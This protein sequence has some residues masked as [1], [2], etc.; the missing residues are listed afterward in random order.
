[1]P[2]AHT[3]AAAASPIAAA[4]APHR[5]APSSSRID[6]KQIP[7]AQVEMVGDE[8]LYYTDCDKAPPASNSTF[9]ALDQGNCNP[10]FVRLT[11]YRVAATEALVDST[12]LVVG[13]IIQPLAR[14]GTDEQQVPVI[15]IDAQNP[16]GPVRCS[17]C[18]AY[19]NHWNKF[20]DQ[21]RRWTCIMC[22]H[23]NKVADYYY[24]NLDANG[25][26]R[27]AGVRA[28]LAYGTVEYAA[29]A[30]YNVRKT[31]ESNILYMI[32]ASQT[33]IQSGLFAAAADGVR[34][35]LKHHAK[36]PRAMIGLCTYG[37]SVNF[38]TTNLNQQ[39][40]QMLEVGDIDDPFVPLPYDH[41][42]ARPHDP[43]G[44]ARLHSILDTMRNVHVNADNSAVA[45]FG[46]AIQV[47]FEALKGTGGRI[48]IVQASMPQHGIGKL[49]PRDD[50]NLY[51]TDKERMLFRPQTD[52]YRNIAVQCAEAGVA[53]DMFVGASGYLDI[54]TT[55][56]LSTSTGGQVYYYDNFSAARSVTLCQDISRNAERESGCDGVMVVRAS[57]GLRPSEYYGNFFRRRPHEIEL[58]GIDADKAFAV[59]FAHDSKLNVDRRACFQCAL[60]YTTADGHRRIR[61]HT[62]A[63]PVTTAMADI[64]RHSDVD[65]IVAL[66]LKQAGRQILHPSAPKKVRAALTEACIDCLAVYRKHCASSTSRGQLILPEPL[67]LLPFYTFGMVKHPLFHGGMYADQRSH[68][69]ACVASMPIA[70][71][72]VFV[73]PALFDVLHMP[74]AACVEEDGQIFLPPTIRLSREELKSDSIYVLDNGFAIYMWVGPQVQPEVQQQLFDFSAAHPGA[75][76]TVSMQWLGDPDHVSSRVHCMFKKI[77]GDRPYFQELDIIDAQQLQQHQM[78]QHQQP[79]AGVGSGLDEKEF[80]KHLIE[81]EGG[82]FNYTKLLQASLSKSGSGASSNKSNSLPSLMSMEQFLCHLHQQIVQRI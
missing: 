33:S 54:A 78:Q 51:N 43:E 5:R 79:Q 15:N 27:D 11:T 35:A 45:A 21:G 26:R 61:V 46:A 19:M 18:R 17:R 58:A 60:L 20:I 72:K 9:T 66:S 55:S 13:A 62:I 7:R 73:C 25:K 16:E 10:R 65:T 57:D 32:E 40:S 49:A 80:M 75:A 77:R 42:F 30:D 47:G 29:P 23:S 37:D 67:K 50:A 24:C 6:Q 38:Y 3:A 71:S 36:N 64:F 56:C 8:E 70:V 53:V 44:L 14:L 2:Q 74:N 48:A 52:H 34:E 76:K 1:M 68:L 41:I 63:V 12:K 59:T 4:G 22:S 31:N 39:R 69:F 28:E 81:D 82:M